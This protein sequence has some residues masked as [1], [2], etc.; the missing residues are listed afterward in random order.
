MSRAAVLKL[1]R[2]FCDDGLE[3]KVR[4]SVQK[5]AITRADIQ[6]VETAIGEILETCHKEMG[7]H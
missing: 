2:G 5:S 7:A 4:E 6:A 3:I 1:S